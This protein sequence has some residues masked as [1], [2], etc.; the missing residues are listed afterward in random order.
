MYKDMMDTI[1]MV[2]AADPEL[3]GE[4][5]GWM[6]G[7]CGEIKIGNEWICHDPY[8]QQDH[9]ADPFDAFTKPTTNRSMKYFVEMI[10]SIEGKEW[11]AKVPTDLPIYNI[12]GDQDPVGMYGEGVYQV[13]NWLAE[14]GHEDVTTEL[15][16]GFRHEIHNY[17]EI[18]DDVADGIIE[19]MD[20]VLAE[21]QID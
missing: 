14:T 13:S 2:N 7:R 3:G 17:A 20:E 11:A 4:L 10:K 6:C 9:A 18:K 5:L 15:Y 21:G 8:V 1:G 19:F 16:T 12:A